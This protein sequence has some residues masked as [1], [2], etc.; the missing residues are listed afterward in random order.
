VAVQRALAYASGYSK[1]K[2][3]A[4]AKTALKHDLSLLT[5]QEG[6]ATMRMSVI[7]DT[8]ELGQLTATAIISKYWPSGVVDKVKNMRSMKGGSGVVFDIN[9]K[10]AEAFL[11]SYEKLKI[12]KKGNV[13]ILVDKC[14]SLPDLENESVPGLRS[15]LG[16]YGGGGGG[17]GRGSYGGY[18]EGGRRDRDGGRSGGGGGGFFNG[19]PKRSSMG[20]GGG[21][22]SSRY[23]GGNSYRD[24]WD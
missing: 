22:G 11:E 13:D 20:R 4:P 18:D 3:N 9:A 17:Y 7:E 12:T 21:R 1:P 19:G 2:S 24:L 14:K 16:S 8:Q 23:G 5:G 15:T 10:E 6:M